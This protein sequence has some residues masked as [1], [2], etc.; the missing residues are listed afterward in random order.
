MSNI[1]QMVMD[2]AKRS[3]FVDYNVIDQR[4]NGYSCWF[5]D[6]KTYTVNIRDLSFDRED[7]IDCEMLFMNLSDALVWGVE[8]AFKYLGGREKVELSAEE[9]RMFEDIMYLAKRNI[10]ID[11]SIEPRDKNV[12]AYG[13]HVRKV[14]TF[15]APIDVTP[16]DDL[17]EGM[18]KQIAIGKEY[19]KYQKEI[20]NDDY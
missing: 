1:F 7:E 20:N 15:G 17:Y 4:A 2:L 5:G 14:W 12:L 6:I 19:L 3:L 11:Y 8:G 9:K 16:F 10:S 13:I 18:K